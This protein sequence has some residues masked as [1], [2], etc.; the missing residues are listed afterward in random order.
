MDNVEKKLEQDIDILVAMSAEMDS[1]LRHEVMFWPMTQSHMPRLTLGGFFLRAHRLTALSALLTP[2]D[3]TRVALALAQFNELAK[4][5]IVALEQRMYEEI[6][7]RLRQ[8]QT[9]LREWQGQAP[10]ITLYATGVEVRAMITAML[11]KL[12]SPPFQQNPQLVE[13]VN[14]LDQALHRRWRPGEFVWPAAWQPAYP[15]E[16][17]SWLYGLPDAG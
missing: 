5:N 6:E 12:D 7:V 11:A 15:Q 1:Y 16:E 3:Q 8:W 13:R 17:Y 9:S 14:S 2:E 4:D 10:T